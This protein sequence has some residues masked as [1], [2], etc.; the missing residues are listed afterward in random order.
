MMKYSFFDEN[1]SKVIFVT[2]QMGILGV[3]IWCKIN[4]DDDNNFYTDDPDTAIYVRLLAW[5]N[6]F[7]KRKALKKKIDEELV[8][9]AWHPTRWRNW[10]LPEDLTKEIE[11]IFT[12][13]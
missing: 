6:K 2:S 13:K 9:V 12:D 4:V 1:F 7:Q 11:S 8:S 3:D 5:R 10:C